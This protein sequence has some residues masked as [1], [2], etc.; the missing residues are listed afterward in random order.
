MFLNILYKTLKKLFQIFEKQ[1]NNAQAKKFKKSGGHLRLRT[2]SK[3]YDEDK[4][5]LG[6]YVDIGENVL[7]RGGAGIV[8]G[9]RC[10]I[11]AG[12]IITSVGHPVELPRWGKTIGKPIKIGDDVWIGA[13][14]VVLPGVQIGNGSVVG[15]GAVV[16]RNVPENCVV[17]G[18]PA[19]VI[20]KIKHFKNQKPPKN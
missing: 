8:V 15:A 2:N 19:Q 18:V 10:L 20:K 12:A 14:A 3:F 7:F 4:I 17:V 11:A 16:T 6:K 9:D 13:N 1:R 5:E